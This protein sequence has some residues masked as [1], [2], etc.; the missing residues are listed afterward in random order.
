[1]LRVLGVDF[2][3]T[4]IDTKS[5][6]ITEIGAVLWSGDTYEKQ[7]SYSALVYE[8]TYLPLSE[9]VRRV[10]GLTDIEL[11]TKGIPPREALT[12]LIKLIE[13]ADF[14]IAH[15]KAFDETLFLAEC[16]RQSI[17]PPTIPWHCSIED[18]EYPEYYRCKK[19]SHLALDHGIIVD[20]A[21]LHR[22]I[23]DVDL[24]GD[25]LRVGAYSPERIRAFALLPWHYLQAV[26]PGPWVGKGGD[27]GKG[28]ELAKAEG[29]SY[30]AVRGTLKP[31][32]DKAW[33]KRVKVMPESSQFAFKFK[34]LE[35]K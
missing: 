6:R 22:A 17:T 3:S 14:V 10:T 25:L 29:F 27:G 12:Q 31:R 8:P 32:F 19:L 30:E 4:G 5:A 20:P 2:E 28:R 16:A 11:Q 23:G 1:M 35:I 9:E 24:L 34:E 21:K 15:N 18:I 26:I 7:D 33:V 13:Q